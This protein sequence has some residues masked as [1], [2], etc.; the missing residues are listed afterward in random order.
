MRRET[1]RAD[2]RNGGAVR[3]DAPLEAGIGL[4]DR[5]ARARGARRSKGTSSGGAR[6]GRRVAGEDKRVRVTVRFRAEWAEEVWVLPDVG[7]RVER[8][9]REWVVADRHVPRKYE[10]HRV[11]LREPGLGPPHDPDEP[12]RV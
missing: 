3:G 8:L 11:E 7:S 2:D 10:D 12:R 6:Y 1:S 4:L 5:L 9:G